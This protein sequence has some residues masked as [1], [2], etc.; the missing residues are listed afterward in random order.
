MRCIWGGVWDSKI[1]PVSSEGLSRWQAGKSSEQTPPIKGPR[2]QSI[3]ETPKFGLRRPTEWARRE[4]C[5][6]R[7]GWFPSIT[8]TIACG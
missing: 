2:Q 7:A 3:L 8:Q 6:V 4:W 5:H 1:L